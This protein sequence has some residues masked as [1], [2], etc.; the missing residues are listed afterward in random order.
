MKLGNKVFQ[1]LFFSLISVCSVI[2]EE[3]IIT[4][5][6]INVEKITPSFEEIEEE[7]ETNEN[8][9]EGEEDGTA[10]SGESDSADDDF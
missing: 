4:T 2:A 1:I 10:Y 9:N 7:S 3:K 8:M 5:P 6:L